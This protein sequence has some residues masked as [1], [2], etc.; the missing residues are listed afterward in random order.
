[1][2]ELNSFYQHSLEEDA[3]WTKSASEHIFRAD[4]HIPLTPKMLRRALGAKLPRSRVFHVTNQQYLKDMIGL[5]GKRK[6]VSA[7]TSIHPTV[8]TGGINVSGGLVFE[9][10]ADVM[11][12]AP[13]DIMSRPDKTGRRWLEWFMLNP[14]GL[15]NGQ[16]IKDEIELYGLRQK[17][18]L[19]YKYDPNSTRG[20]QTPLN[21][22]NRAWELID[23]RN[24]RSPLQKMIPF[25]VADR[26]GGNM[27]GGEEPSFKDIK[28]ILHYMIKD[29]IDAMEKVITKYAY[30]ISTM[31]WAHVYN[32][33]KDV[34]DGWDE[35]VVNNFKIKEILIHKPTVLKG[36]SRKDE[37]IQ[38][39]GWENFIKEIESTGIS[40]EVFEEAKD[41]SNEVRTRSILG[42]MKQ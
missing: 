26:I 4:L 30:E 12:S 7:A 16:K 1:M 33:N 22:V 18:D 38:E 5:Q 23:P 37:D 42:L 20:G 24:T 13:N 29:Y 15:P 40:Y 6:S 34:T 11:V 3:V 25:S 9:L 19:I 27:K 21:K 31:F 14:K 32:A 2:P 8:V 36:F 35:L 17:R 39:E 10:D 28:K 41:I